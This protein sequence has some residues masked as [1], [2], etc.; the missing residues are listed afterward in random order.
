MYLCYKYRCSNDGCQVT[1]GEERT[2]TRNRIEE[3][4]IRVEGQGLDVGHQ[5]RDAVTEQNIGL[6]VGPE[7][8]GV[9]GGDGWRWQGSLAEHGQNGVDGFGAGATDLTTE[10][11][12]QSVG[13]QGQSVVGI[14]NV[15][16]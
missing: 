10:K 11:G 3:T 9:D 8:L 2:D 14:G 6:E 4:S 1:G 13:A 7:A 5:G 12:L 15:E 16:E